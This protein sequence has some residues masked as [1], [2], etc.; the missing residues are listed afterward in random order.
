MNGM[1][2]M[3]RAFEVWHECCLGNRQNKKQLENKLREGNAQMPASSQ[4]FT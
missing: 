3:G 2:A 4:I 1:G